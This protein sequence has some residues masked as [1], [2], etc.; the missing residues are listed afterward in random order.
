MSDPTVEDAQLRR[1]RQSQRR[2]DRVLRWL[3]GGVLV[4]TIVVVAAAIGVLTGLVA[5]HVDRSDWVASEGGHVLVG[6][7]VTGSC[8]QI[9]GS[10]HPLFQVNCDV[11]VWNESGGA[12]AV[13]GVA[14]GAPFHS[15]LLPNPGPCDRGTSC[16]P[17]SQLDGP[18]RIQMP[19]QPGT[20]E[21]RGTVYAF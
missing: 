11:Q 8:T 21:L 15:E 20:Y 14:V 10:Y 18:V 6:A 2:R 7:T 13:S 19:W 3:I 1:Y 17:Q 4:A 12:L 9:Q 16:F 5:V